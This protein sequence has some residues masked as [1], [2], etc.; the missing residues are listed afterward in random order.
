MPFDLRTI[1]PILLTAEDHDLIDKAVNNLKKSG[2]A[3]T[4]DGSS[5][6]VNWC[7]VDGEGEV[8]RSPATYCYAG[9]ATRL[10]KEPKFLV[11][12]LMND[13]KLG[14]SVED[15]HAFIDYI[16]NRSPYS[17]AFVA[18]DRMLPDNPAENVFGKTVCRTDV[19]ANLIAAGLTAIRMAWEYKG[20]AAQVWHLLTKAGCDEDLAYAFAF[21]IK[22]LNHRSVVLEARS[23]GHSSWDGKQFTEKM[24]S[25]YLNWQLVKV[26]DNYLDQCSDKA[27]G[28]DY[29]PMCTAWGTGKGDEYY[30]GSDQSY[31]CEERSRVA[32]I[33]NGVDKASAN[34]FKKAAVKEIPLE[35]F[36]Q[37]W[38]GMLMEKC[39]PLLEKRNEKKGNIDVA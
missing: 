3:A 25:N 34:V 26:K 2:I 29:R 18:K 11:A 15:R 9:M 38:A 5:T 30:Y 23:E 39:A 22:T 12:D 32:N 37:I 24:L 6:I 33:C 31:L 17:P 7:V 36:C 28:V 1:E 8:K 4:G 19:P 10:L 35:Q 14:P 21:Q 16:I 20:D 13:G 27:Y